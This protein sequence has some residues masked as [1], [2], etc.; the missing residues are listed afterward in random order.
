MRTDARGIAST[1][2]DAEINS[3]R[4][5]GSGLRKARGSSAQPAVS[6]LGM[7]SRDARVTKNGHEDSRRPFVR[8]KGAARED[9]TV[10][11]E[12]PPARKARRLL[13]A[14]RNANTERVLRYLT[15]HKG[16]STLCLR[17]VRDQATWELVLEHG[18]DP[19]AA[20]HSAWDDASCAAAIKRGA[21]VNHALHDVRS[22][23][24]LRRLFRHGADPNFE[25]DGVSLA[26]ALFDSG[27]V[28]LL[29]MVHSHLNFDPERVKNWRAAGPLTPSR[30]LF[31][32]TPQRFIAE[33]Y[34]D[35]GPRFS[36]DQGTVTTAEPDA[37]EAL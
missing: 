11:K 8:L 29:P 5:D 12:T 15:K 24:V 30:L 13:Q 10:A 2:T 9:E 21:N 6:A 37:A 31:G 36:G 18:A 19:T 25:K 20:L 7:R 34:G 28:T 26:D 27:R 4:P 22:D 23:A 1:I 33:L 16:I 35:E 32:K 3:S 14:L 17:A